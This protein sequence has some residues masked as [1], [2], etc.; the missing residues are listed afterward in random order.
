MVHLSFVNVVYHFYWWDP[1]HFN[2]AIQFV[3]KFMN[4]SLKNKLHQMTFNQI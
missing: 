3:T 2:N 4:F 1:W